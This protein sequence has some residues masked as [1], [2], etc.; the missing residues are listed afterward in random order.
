MVC[1]HTGDTQGRSTGTAAL[2][3]CS[4]KSNNDVAVLRRTPPLVTARAHDSFYEAIH[5]IFLRV[6][7]N[8]SHGSL[9][10]G[11]GV[12]AVVHKPW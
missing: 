4:H 12:P 10:R 9:P 8:K 7:S 5:D 1:T 6:E 11:K 2:S 3:S